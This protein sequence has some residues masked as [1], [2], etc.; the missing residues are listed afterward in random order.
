M[1]QAVQPVWASSPKLSKANRLSLG[2]P[3]DKKACATGFRDGLDPLEF[4]SLL[5]GVIARARQDLDRIVCIGAAVPG[6]QRDGH[7]SLCFG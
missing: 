7:V 2:R 1:E 4:L 5:R 3:R 6:E